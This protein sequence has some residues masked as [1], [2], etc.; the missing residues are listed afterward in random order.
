[1]RLKHSAQPVPRPARRLRQMLY[2]ALAATLLTGAGWLIAHFWLPL[3]EDAAR[4]PLETWSIR[5]HGLAAMFA[6]AVH[7]AYWQQHIARASRQRRHFASGMLLLAGWLTL[8]LSGYGLYYLTDE[9][10]RAD[11]SLA[12]WLTGLAIPVLLAAHMLSRQGDRRPGF[13]L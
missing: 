7:G 4:H 11:T 2:L 13:G 12:H 1:M 10:L 8:I 6:L 3:P 5:A 9:G